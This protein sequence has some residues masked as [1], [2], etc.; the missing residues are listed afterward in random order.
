MWI[1]RRLEGYGSAAMAAVAM[2]LVV[3]LASPIVEMVRLH[4][5]EY[6][7]YNRFV[8]G[9][10]GARKLFM[11]DYWGL[12]LTQAARELHAR[13]APS[14]RIRR[15]AVCGPHPPVRIAMGPGYTTTWKPERADFALVLGEHFC[16]KLDAPVLLKIVQEGVVY[17]RVY[18]LRGRSISTSLLAPE[19]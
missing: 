7:Y 9:V 18:D 14:S 1:V 12:S 11:V 17:A 6:T 16:A 2:V 3:G 13:I 8:G 5:Y 15:L 4:P 19:P 10:P